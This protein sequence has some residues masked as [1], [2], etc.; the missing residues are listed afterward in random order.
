MEVHW[1]EPIMRSG[2]VPASTNAVAQPMHIDWPAKSVSRKK[3]WN[4]EIHHVQ[5][6]TPQPELGMEGV[7]SIP[8]ID[9]FA[10]DTYQ[11]WGTYDSLTYNVI[12]LEHQVAFV[13]RK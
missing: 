10:H 11:V 4:W 8:H 12:P 6:V 5:T 13:V 2:T 1:S 9:V 7:E 3:H